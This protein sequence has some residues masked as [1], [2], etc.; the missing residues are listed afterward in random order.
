MPKGLLRFQGIRKKLIIYY[1]IIMLLLSI[2]SFFS[3]Y[4][5]KLTLNRMNFILKDYVYLNELNNEVSMLET[6]V[7]KYLTTKSSE[8]LL[9]YYNHYNKLQGKAIEI[10]RKSVFQEQGLMLKDIAYMIDNLL[11]ETDKAISAK[12]GRISSEYIAHFKRSN[13]IGGYIKFYISELLNKKLQE[14]SEKY[15]SI[16]QNMTYISYI[17]L[18]IIILSVII[19]AVLAVIF[20]YRLTKPLIELSHSAESISKGNYNVEPINIRTDDEITILSDAFNKMVIN[21]RSHINEIRGQAEMETK[22]K[23]QEMQ[24]FK[25]KS[26]LKDAELK[27]L[28]AQINPHFLFNTLN[29]ASQLAMLEGADKSS[30]FIYKVS[31]LFRYNL[32]K[33]DKPV[34]IGE[35]VNNVSIYMDILK[36][37]FGEKIEFLIDVDENLMNIPIPCTIIQPVVENAYIHGLEDLERKGTI[38]LSVKASGNKIFIEVKDNGIGMDENTVKALLLSQ[39]HKESFKKHVSGIGIHNVI[40]RLQL[41]YNLDAVEDIIDIHSEIGKGTVVRLKIPFYVEGGSDL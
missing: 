15:S 40:N 26:L 8:A 11:I 20:T 33:L 32:R 7:E 19:N 10:P 31:E 38:L 4:N 5:A 24:N 3:Y 37:R 41:F 36:T 13:E 25:M 1:F 27:S 30:E 12:R 34:S 17:N 23:E 35:E 39:Y 6:E 21:I 29:A 16:T 18:T 2:T 28:Q 14:G 22:L 9:E